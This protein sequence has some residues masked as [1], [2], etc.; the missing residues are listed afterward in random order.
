MNEVSRF[1]KHAALGAAGGLAGTLAL[2]GLMAAGRRWAPDSLPPLREE[3]GRF[4]IRKMEKAL[5]DAT[6]VRIPESVEKAAAA[7]LGVDYG[8]AF[9]ALYGLL[10]PHGGHPLLDGLALGAACWAAGY[11]GWLPALG[12]TP[13][14]WRQRPAQALAPA[15]EHLVYGVVAVA[16]HDGLRSAFGSREPMS[17]RSE[18]RGRAASMASAAL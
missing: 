1:L 15:M 17:V 13:P 5:P 18:A 8:V 16:A 12:L 9:G 4:M 2:Q 6:R 11:L 10:R 7:G 14:V 3:P